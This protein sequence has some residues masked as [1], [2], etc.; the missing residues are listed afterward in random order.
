RRNLPD[1][2][3]LMRSPPLVSLGPSGLVGTLRPVGCRGQCQLSTR[4]GGGARLVHAGS[5]FGIAGQPP[6]ARPVAGST[7][8]TPPPYP[9][10]TSRPPIMLASVTTSEWAIRQA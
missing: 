4:F 3:A 1:T 8:F 6:V 10:S 5:T 7:A 2:W 9:V